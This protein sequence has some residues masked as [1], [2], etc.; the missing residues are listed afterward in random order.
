M[1]AKERQPLSPAVRGRAA[2][3]VL[4]PAGLVIVL[5]T[6]TALGLRAYY[7]SRAGLPS[8]APGLA[9]GRVLTAAAGVVC[10][11]LM[12]RLVRHRGVFAALVACGV[13]AVFPDS[14]QPAHRVLVEP[15]L[16]LF[17]LIGAVVVFR[18]DRLAAG[19]WLVAGGAASGFA[20]VIEPWAIAPVAVVLVLCL[21]DPRPGKARLSRAWRFAAGVTAGF[22]LP[23]LRFAVAAPRGSAQSLFGLR[24]GAGPVPVPARLV[25]LTGLGGVRTPV[26]VQLLVTSL[27]LSYVQAA[28]TMAAILA[29]LTVGVPVVLNLITSQRPS[30]LD[31]FALGS[32]ALLVAM[33]L[34]PGQFH[35]DLAAL[36]APFLGLAIALPFSQLLTL[37]LTRRPLRGPPPRHPVRAAALACSVVILALFAVTQA[38]GDSHRAPVAAA[39]ATAYVQHDVTVMS[40]DRFGAARHGRV[41]PGTGRDRHARR[42]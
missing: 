6:L 18:R 12:G 3:A 10:V 30:P 8:G 5:A 24:S 40:T 28:W 22:C 35:H 2:A 37:R 41:A 34:W 32:A 17:C 14:A 38:R 26:H 42:G 36:L 19:W 15:W 23:A 39:A 11:P 9:I 13:L 7:L 25:E 33:F 27:T 16:V 29:A 31:W 21:A 4:A 1:S 20:G